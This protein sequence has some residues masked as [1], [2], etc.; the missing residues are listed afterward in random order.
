MRKALCAGSFDPITNGHMDIIERAASIFDQVLVTV[1]TNPAKESA[2]SLEDRLE[3]VQSAV[4]HLDNVVVDS[5]TGLLV[6][7]ARQH[8][9]RVIIK[10]LRA[11]SDFEYEF[12][13]A[14]MNKWLDDRVETL[15]MMTKPQHSYLSSSIIRELYS[16]GSDIS[17]LVPAGVLEIIKERWHDDGMPMEREKGWD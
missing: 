7:Y 16:L 3:M 11:V 6:D 15:F 12:Q 17:Q 2:F 13:Q 14:Q 10:G 1:F 9:V 4:S 5:A 8:D